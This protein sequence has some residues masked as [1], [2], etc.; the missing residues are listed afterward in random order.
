MYSKIIHVHEDKGY[1]IRM[2]VSE[3]RGVWYVN[4]RKYYLTYEGEYVPS[5][6]GVAFPA[7]FGNV[8]NL[9]RGSLDIISKEEAKREL[10][11]ALTKLLEDVNNP[12]ELSDIPF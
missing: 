11:Q 12:P 7:E 8:L 9:V 3:F 1:D 6:E 5:N 4:L 10:A 2:T